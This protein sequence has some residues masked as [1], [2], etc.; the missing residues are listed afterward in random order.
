MTRSKTA[1]LGIAVA[2]VLPLSFYIIAK[3]MGKDRL[4][5][6]KYYNH[7]DTLSSTTAVQQIEA[8]KLDPV[9]EFEGTNQFGDPV[10][11]NAGLKNRLLVV[12]VFFTTCTSTCPKLTQN[13]RILEFAFRRTP[14]A[15]NDTTVQFVSI[16][17]DPANDTTEALRNYA[18][19]YK[20]DENHWWFVRADKKYSYDWIRNQLHLSA[21]GGDGGADD[22]IHSNTIVVLD[23]DRYIRGYYDGLDTASIGKCAYDLG[24]LAMEKKHK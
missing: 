17:V 13:L 18:R 16:T 1:I 24:L 3:S 5:M 7:Q 8:G 2:L 11:L 15:R 10:K 21:P 9:P 12:N 19:K 20:A 23:R 14:M 6:P 22:F 4:D